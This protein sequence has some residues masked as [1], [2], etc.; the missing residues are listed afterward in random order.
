MRK[1]IKEISSHP[2]TKVDLRKVKELCRLLKVES[3][4]EAIRVVVE[5][6]LLNHHAARS[7][8]RFLDALAH[9]QSHARS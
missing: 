4:E 7:L 8:N 3:E 6:S 1:K 9:E 5:E 2:K